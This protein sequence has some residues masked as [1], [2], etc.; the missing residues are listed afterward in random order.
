M[1]K[2]NNNWSNPDFVKEYHREYYQ[3]NKSI[4]NKKSIL[5]AKNNKEK[6]LGYVRKS[7]FGIDIE[8]QNLLLSGNCE[9]CLN[10]KA[11]HIDHDHKTNIVRG[12]L[13]NNCNTGLGMFSDDFD[14]LMNAAEYVKDKINNDKFIL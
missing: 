9:I 1:K 4:L 8:T 14:T 7:K 6:H 10:R 12:G 5:W 3:K 13:C 11:T 2:N